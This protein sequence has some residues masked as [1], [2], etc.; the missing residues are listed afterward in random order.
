MSMPEIWAFVQCDSEGL[1]A[2]SQEA[3]GEG[4]R[5]ADE[6]GARLV[7]LSVG[8]DASNRA[9]EAFDYGADLAL[10]LE[11][12]GTLAGRAEVTVP[13]IESL[14]R[15]RQPKVILVGATFEGKVLAAT[16]AARLSVGLVA[17]SSRLEMG[18]G[19]RLKAYVP[20]FGGSA[21]F[22][23][24]REPQ[25]VS[26]QRGAYQSPESR[27]RQ[28]EVISVVPGVCLG[29]GVRV[30]GLRTETSTGAQLEGAGVIVAGGMG[31]GSLEGWKVLE[32]VARGLGAALGATRPAVDEGWAREEQMIGQ[33]GK[34][35]KP[36]FY[37]A[38]GISGDQLHLCGVKGPEVFIAINKDPQAP[39]F[40]HAHFG[41]VADCQKILP[42]LLRL[43]GEREV[44]VKPG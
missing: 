37:L 1:M 31:L 10:A 32:G 43:L 33:S 42:H 30:T 3:L 20:A 11:H 17:H 38:V 24:S 23:F 28:G 7:S 36:R 22:C 39:I 25:M 19:C 5:L 9:E 2:V 41:I 14:A 8:E 29:S 15:E 6:C 35:V 44:Q 12:P 21:V 4:R 16:L 40:Q 27:R 13:V 26:I 18:P 34:T